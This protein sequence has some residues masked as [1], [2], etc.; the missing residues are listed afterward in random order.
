MAREFGAVDLKPCPFC[1]QKPAPIDTRVTGQGTQ[2][3]CGLC[4]ACGPDWKPDDGRAGSNRTVGEAH[5][6]WNQRAEGS[7]DA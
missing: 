3:Y 2:V 4:G 5:G 6:T 1:G 7:A